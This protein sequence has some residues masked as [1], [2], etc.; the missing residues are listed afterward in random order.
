MKTLH[1]LRVEE[2]AEIF[3]P[4]VVALEG[5]GLRAG[6]LEFS[7]DSAPVPQGLSAAAS[8]GVL[9]AVSV[10]PAGAV[11]VKP[12]R[13][14]PVLKDL[15]REHFSGCRLV[16]VLGPAPAPILRSSSQSWCLSL[17]SGEELRLSSED[18]AARLRRPAPWPSWCR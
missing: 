3:H 17:E 18:L 10:G 16:L 14:E 7:E 8:A 2:G 4:L 12:R 1:L 6:W 5:I 13:G 11:I 15:L 9:R